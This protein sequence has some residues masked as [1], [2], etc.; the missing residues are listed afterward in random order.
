MVA[1]ADDDD[2]DDEVKKVTQ[3]A[4]HDII[5]QDEKE[6]IELSSELKDEANDDY[7]DTLLKIEDLIN[8]FLTDEFLEGKPILSITDELIK[9]SKGIQSQSRNSID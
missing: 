5:H 4:F 1:D 2:D 8:V 9:H 3:S 6:L 7:I